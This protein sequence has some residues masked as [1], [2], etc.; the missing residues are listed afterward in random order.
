MLATRCRYSDRGR[1]NATR[2]VLL[3][4]AWSLILT[5][6]YQ[7]VAPNK[8]CANLTN[9]HVCIAMLT[10]CRRAPRILVWLLPPFSL[11]LLHSCT[12]TCWT[13]GSGTSLLQQVFQQVFKCCGAI[14]KVIFKVRKI[15]FGPLLSIWVNIL[16]TVYAMTNVCVYEARKLYEV[17]LWFFS[18]PYD[19]WWPLKV[20]ELSR[21]CIS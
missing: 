15:Q 17:I 2:L 7:L 20:T 10:W 12:P 19:F 8:N 16:E 6:G 21:G 4:R 14:V 18:L 3:Y 11:F 5:D 9:Y 13:C 1:T